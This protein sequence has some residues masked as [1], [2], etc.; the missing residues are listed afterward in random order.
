MPA[1][2]VVTVT[3]CGY[4]SPVV[5]SPTLLQLTHKTLCEAETYIEQTWGTIVATCSGKAVREI[6]DRLARGRFARL[7]L[8]DDRVGQVGRQA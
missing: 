6:H 7:V 4:G 3:A 2:E 8:L 1:N 5:G